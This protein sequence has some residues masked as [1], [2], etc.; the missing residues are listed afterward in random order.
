MGNVGPYTSDIILKNIRV[1]KRARFN[2]GTG[3]CLEAMRKVAGV[4][5]VYGT[6]TLAGDHAHIHT[7]GKVNDIPDGVF[8][9]WGERDGHI[10]W[11]RGMHDGVHYCLTP[12]SPDDP[13][14]WVRVP[15]A[16]IS[17]RWGHTL[18][19]WSRDIDGKTI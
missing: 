12:G 1:L 11:S 19:G 10:A 4:D 15:T 5:S 16:L 8:I 7:V 18:R 2:I 3:H 17:S 9:Y 14:H 13:N 6:A